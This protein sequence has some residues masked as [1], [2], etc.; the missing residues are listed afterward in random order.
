[1]K[2]RIVILDDGWK[3]LGKSEIFE[4]PF[5]Q[6]PEKDNTISKEILSSEILWTNQ[7]IKDFYKEILGKYTYYTVLAIN[8][9][10]DRKTSE[11]IIEILIEI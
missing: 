3:L 8:F 2:T 6:L 1:M 11:K 10:H 9:F 5:D 7:G 4:W